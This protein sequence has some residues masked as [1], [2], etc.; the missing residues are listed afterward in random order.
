M[1]CLNVL[2]KQYV[3]LD[4][5]VESALFLFLFLWLA[6]SVAK[7]LGIVPLSAGLPLD[8]RLLRLNEHCE[9]M[10]DDDNGDDGDDDYETLYE[11]NTRRGSLCYSAGECRKGFTDLDNF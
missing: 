6:L 7:F 1:G 10:D 8:R 2:L 11:L 9:R 4:V 3:V 5:D